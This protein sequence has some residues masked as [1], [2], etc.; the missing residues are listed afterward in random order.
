MVYI[1]Y[2]FV[3]S[4]NNILLFIAVSNLNVVAL[5]D[6]DY[7]FTSVYYVYILL[8]LFMNFCSLQIKYINLR[9]WNRVSWKIRRIYFNDGRTVTDVGQPGDK[10]IGRCR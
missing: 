2:L 7:Y 5:F 3:I 4:L 10:A 8:F 9:R 1:F 6:I